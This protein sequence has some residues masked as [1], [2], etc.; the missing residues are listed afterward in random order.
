MTELVDNRSR[1]CVDF[2]SGLGGFSQA[3][4]D[5]GWNVFT[6]D[7]DER[8]EPTLCSDIMDVEPRQLPHRADVV[9][10]SPPCNCFSIAS[11]SKHWNRDKTPKETAEKSIGY[12]KRALW[13]KDQLEPDFWVLENPRGMLQHV[14]GRPRLTFYQAMFG[15]RGQ[16]ATQFWGN[17]PDAFVSY[18]LYRQK[19]KDFTWEKAPRGSK[20]GTQ[21]IKDRAERAKIPYELSLLLCSSVEDALNE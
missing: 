18:V 5:R 17:I 8:F 19:V 12:V 3:F 10:M 2:F 1:I 14:L 6:V 15:T 20:T 4:R 13:L 7:I 21:G 9:L 11:V 16:K